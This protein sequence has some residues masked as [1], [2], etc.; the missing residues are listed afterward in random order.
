[1]S[2]MKEKILLVEDDET[3]ASGLLYAL[4]KEGYEPFHCKNVDAASSLTDKEQFDLAILDRQLP[5]GS[6]T[7]IAEKLFQRQTPVIFLT[8]VDDENEI[9]RSF[10][11]GAADYITKPFRLRELLARI[12]RTLPNQT[13]K[14][15]SQK[16]VLQNAV[17]DTA[18][19]KVF[20]EGERIELTAL[21]YRLLLIFAA[22][23]SVLLTRDQIMEKIW[24]C[25]GNFV[26]DNTL[27]VYIRRLR[28]KL[29]DAVKIETVR[30][31]G[32]RV[33]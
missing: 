18:A 31:I 26:E 6:G 21:E 33:D 28:K 14:D 16:C 9:V 22:N 25:T 7:V 10:E 4:E 23:R 32:Y 5:D 24:D 11:N 17:I 19:G 13:G 30:G 20:V 3:I 29:G 27:T 2:A 15:T 1:M 8:V 12:K